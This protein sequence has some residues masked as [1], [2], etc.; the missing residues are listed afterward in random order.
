MCKN[1]D[2]SSNHIN[3]IEPVCDSLALRDRYHSTFLN[4]RPVDVYGF[5]VRGYFRKPS[6][7]Q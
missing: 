2:L 5:E 4:H 3:N 6:S 1:T 7:S